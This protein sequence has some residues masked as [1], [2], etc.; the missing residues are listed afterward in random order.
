MRISAL[1]IYPQV[2]RFLNIRGIDFVEDLQKYNF[3]DLQVKLGVNK[4][5]LY[6]L[7]DSI[8]AYYKNTS[9]K[10]TEP[11][12]DEVPI[13]TFTLN[14]MISES[15]SITKEYS[16]NRNYI[17]KTPE[18]SLNALK[19]IE[20]S[21][22]IP[23]LND[24]SEPVSVYETQKAQNI[25]PHL[26]S[27]VKGEEEGIKNLFWGQDSTYF[28][29]KDIQSPSKI[30]TSTDTIDEPFSSSHD[31][32]GKRIREKESRLP[33]KEL[34]CN[35]D[36]PVGLY[37]TTTHIHVVEFKI[38]NYVLKLEHVIQQKIPSNIVSSNG[39]ILSPQ[40]LILSLKDFWM[41]NRLKNR[42]VV[43]VLWGPR[44][45]V[46]QADFLPI[47]D[48]LLGETILSEVERYAIFAD[49]NVITDYVVTKRSP[50]A[51][52]VC[53]AACDRLL[54]ENYR[55]WLSQAGLSLI[56]TDI[57]QL[58]LLRALIISEEIITTDEWWVLIMLPGKVVINLWYN[59]E[60]V[61]WKE[62]EIEVFENLEGREEERELANN[63]SSEITRLL[64]YLSGDMQDYFSKPLIVISQNHKDSLWLSRQLEIKLEISTFTPELTQFLEWGGIPQTT[65]LIA[66][67]AGL[68][69]K[70]ITPTPALNLYKSFSLHGIISSFLNK[71]APSINLEILKIP[72]FKVSKPFIVCC[73]LTLIIIL[74]T[75]GLRY[76]LQNELKVSQL[77]NQ[78]VTQKQEISVSKNTELIKLQGIESLISNLRYWPINRLLTTI[79]E[80]IPMDVWIKSINLNNDGQI[81][82]NCTALNVTSAAIFSYML[83]Q[84]KCIQNSKLKDINEKVVNKYKI[85]EFSIECILL[86]EQTLRP[87]LN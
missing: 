21:F 6:Y 11:V 43:L 44:I 85:Y 19:T 68:W 42:K 20:R 7:F 16:Q 78:I 26:T 65:P 39:K 18:K 24:E 59:K 53:L 48:D 50:E 64:Q 1:E 49:C 14:K 34:I 28:S 22:P 61:S 79:K 76:W 32:P 40:G 80:N 60:L 10:T 58:A 66:V 70:S 81:L 47:P 52:K 75:Q 4:E 55:Y 25:D 5:V 9:N 29:L 82:I 33:K 46:H 38:K 8:N 87:Q 30:D 63:I 45:L 41:A 74:L 86:K 17:E 57:A 84:E 77:V 83:S 56:A 69:A 71:F 23:R 27:P 67:G 35:Q 12:L 73:V 13:K 3:Y 36:F 72:G 37:I 15:I 51:I 31:E 54:I 62:I 2:C